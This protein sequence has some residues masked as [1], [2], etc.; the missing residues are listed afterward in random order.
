MDTQK[1]ARSEQGIS[2]NTHFFSSLLVARELSPLFMKSFADRYAICLYRADTIYVTSDMQRLLLQAAHDLPDDVTY[3]K[4][5]LLTPFGFVYLEE[6]IK[7]EDRS[8]NT[9]TVKGFAWE[10]SLI[11]T[12][13]EDDFDVSPTA[14]VYFLTDPNDMD[15]ELNRELVPKLKAAGIQLP[16][17]TLSHMFP[18][19]YGRTIIK[20]D[21]QG[22]HLVTEMMK[23]FVALQLLAQQKIGTPMKLRPN[24]AT[25]KRAI[26]WDRDNE[27]YI[28]LITLRRKSVKKDDEE[29]NKIEW[30]HRWMVRGHWRRQ[31][32][33]KS[34]THDWVYIYEHVKGP[35]DKPLLISERRVFNFRR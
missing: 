25:R 19:I 30:T 18:A 15:D 17:L 8:G 11:R 24:R 33:P 2:Y 23:L 28:T 4:E 29:P 13:S 14:L 34:K 35:E 12:G 20:A 21:E 3:Q 27:R 31:Y 6:S 32:F 16:S 22:S 10:D 5:S 9:V 26:S 1:H 7:G